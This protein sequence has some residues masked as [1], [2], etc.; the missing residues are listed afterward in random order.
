[1]G[2]AYLST[3]LSQTHCKQQNCLAHTRIRGWRL[4][5][6]HLS[7]GP[8]KNRS[9]PEPKP[10]DY[11]SKQATLDGEPAASRSRCALLGHHTTCNP[12]QDFPAASKDRLPCSFSTRL[13]S[14][15][16]RL[17][18][19]FVL[20][21]RGAWAAQKAVC[22]TSISKLS[23]RLG[24]PGPVG[25]AALLVARRH[26][27][28]EGDKLRTDQGAVCTAGAADRDQSGANG[29]TQSTWGIQQRRKRYCCPMHGR[30]PLACRLWHAAIN[31]HSYVGWQADSIRSRNKLGSPI[32]ARSIPPH[33]CRLWYAASLRALRMWYSCASSGIWPW[34]GACRKVG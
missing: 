22:C 7:S 5:V 23:A 25:G 33:T 13:P 6:A 19:S 32:T 8:E 17:P 21:R 12:P 28:A 27:G 14:S 1:M 34:T 31:W 20:N 11:Y 24:A 26:V 2:P 15:F 16:S 18:C 29:S 3:L 10:S 9:T 30:D 4:G